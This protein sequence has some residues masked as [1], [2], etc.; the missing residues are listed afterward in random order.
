[1]KRPRITI[2]ELTLVVLVVALALAAIRAGSAPWAGTMMSIT[3]F[4]MICSLLGVALGRGPRRVYWLG[5]AVLGWSYLLLT[6][7]PWL[8]G[9]VGQF[10]LAP[11]LFAYLDE[12]LHPDPQGAGGLQSLPV[13]LLGATATGGGFGGGTASA[14]D[15]ANFVRIGVTMEALLWAFLGGWVARYFA[16]GQNGASAPH[17]AAREDALH[18]S[19]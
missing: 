8:H 11:N 7:V 17:V 6:F 18:A 12:V 13:G 10:V 9:N 19:E 5:F 16:S 2:A 15:S 4:A 1:M 14:Q 3:F